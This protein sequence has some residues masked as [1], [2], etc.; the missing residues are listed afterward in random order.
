MACCFGVLKLTSSVRQ[1]QRSAWSKVVLVAVEA[2]PPAAVRVRISASERHGFGAAASLS[3]KTSSQHGRAG[4]STFMP[5]LV[6]LVG[7]A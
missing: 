1:N 3:T 6:K 2:E 4:G 7:P 5:K